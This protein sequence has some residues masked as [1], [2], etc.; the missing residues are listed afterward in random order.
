[1]IPARRDLLLASSILV[2]KLA[3]TQDE[4]IRASTPTYIFK[5]KGLC[6][7]EISTSVVVNEY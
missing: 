3:K 7:V 4:M 6:I 1:M 2:Y 5:V